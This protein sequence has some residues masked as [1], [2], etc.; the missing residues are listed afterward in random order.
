[1]SAAIPP[2]P[3][4]VFMA[5]CLLKDRDNFAFQLHTDLDGLYK[6]TYASFSLTFLAIFGHVHEHFKRLR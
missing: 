6:S 2:L 5:W 3:Q 4:N 1:M